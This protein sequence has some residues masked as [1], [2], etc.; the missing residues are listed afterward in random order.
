MRPAGEIRRALLLACIELHTPE[1]AATLREIAAQS[2]VG[3]DAARR[4]MD[5]MRR[6]AQVHIARQR[7]VAYRNRPVAEYAPGPGAAQSASPSGSLD[8]IAQ[9]WA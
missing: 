8:I 2:C 1:R 9:A 3:L 5:H 4:T 7:R 6:S